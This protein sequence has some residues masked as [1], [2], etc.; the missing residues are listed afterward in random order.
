[1]K[2]KK[3]IILI[4]VATIILFTLYIWNT[5]NKKVTSNN[6]SNNNETAEINYKCQLK[7]INTDQGI[8]QQTNEVII[9]NN[10]INSYKVGYNLTYSNEE[11]Y[12]NTLQYLF[13]QNTQQYQ[14]LGNKTIYYYILF[15]DFLN[16]CFTISSFYVSMKH[17]KK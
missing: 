8:T 7:T 2:N 11:L 1:M 5:N 6:A 9:Q 10:V 3:Y 16:S 14:D 12:N 13:T 17:S 4:I 15:N